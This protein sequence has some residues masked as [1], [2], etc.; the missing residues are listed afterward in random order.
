MPVTKGAQASCVPPYYTQVPPRRGL[1][2][3]TQCVSPFL[4]G[5]RGQH[6]MGRTRAW[7]QSHT[8]GWQVGK[9]VIDVLGSLPTEQVPTR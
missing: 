5:A 4:W 9:K 1:S 8:L 7:V 3:D 6:A 2:P